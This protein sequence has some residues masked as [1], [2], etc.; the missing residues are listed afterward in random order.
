MI[1]KLDGAARSMDGQK[2]YSYDS[3]KTINS[4]LK[5]TRRPIGDMTTRPKSYWCI[6]H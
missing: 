6:N 5:P 3:N 1:L 2:G 4:H